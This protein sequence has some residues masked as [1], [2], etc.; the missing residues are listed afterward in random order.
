MRSPSAQP[1][2]FGSEQHLVG[3]YH[4]PMAAQARDLGI[5]ICG[6]QG[7]DELC[8]HWS[9]R[10]LAQR[11]AEIG[12]P[13]L[14][15]DYAGTGDSLGD[16]R[17]AGRVAA[18]Q[19]S[20]HQAIDELKVRA[21]VK[22]VALLGVRLGATLAATVAAQRDDIEAVAFY[23]PSLSG[24][25][26]VR[27]LKALGLT[28][29]PDD[30]IEKTE[31]PDDVVM[32]GWLITADTAAA[33]SQLDLAK[34]PKPPAKKVLILHR[35]TFPPDEKPQ[36]AWA[37]L[38]ANVTVAKTQDWE[39]FMQDALTGVLPERDFATLSSWLG[40]QSS[41]A[42]GAG[43]DALPVNTTLR[44]SAWREEL[45][46]LPGGL[47]GV[48]CEPES[49]KNAPLL[50]FL[51][52]AANHHIGPHRSWV[53]FARAL[54]ERGVASFRLDVAGMGDSPV[55]SGRLHNQVYSLAATRDVST[56]VD[57]LHGR[58][59]NRITLIGLC[60]GGYLAFHAAVRDSRVNGLVVINLQ[61]FIWHPGDSLEVARRLALPST[62]TYLQRAMQPQTWKR[63]AKGGIDLRLLGTLFTVRAKKR[64][65]A[66]ALEVLANVLGPAF[67][68]NEV[69]RGLMQLLK[70]GTRVLLVYGEKDG[71]LD[72]LATHLGPKLHRLKQFR[73]VELEYL[74]DSDHTLTTRTAREKLSE[75][76]VRAVHQVSMALMVGATSL[77]SSLEAFLA[78]HVLFGI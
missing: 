23:G 44:G 15:F 12:L 26:Y 38:G 35:Q 30:P 28:R 63:L 71:G 46:T 52:T 54:A 75:L 5:V 51:N 10:N 11:L 77:S 1:H 45:V 78:G 61:R 62:E 33:L 49:K 72:E 22:R 20:V 69:P 14:R 70:R 74:S 17:Q 50:M 8:V 67:E 53:D 68:L 32:A 39:G 29:H 42:V 48:L 66:K 47:F 58:G 16:D 7:Y 13:T 21:G 73:N 24:R 34:L 6:P 41:L 56:A 65:K 64:V 40:E 9:L 59:F 55:E 25:Q 76:F 2:V 36:R 43:L 18:W 3:W 27:E 60:S 31:N 19:A 37:A 57:V 4:P